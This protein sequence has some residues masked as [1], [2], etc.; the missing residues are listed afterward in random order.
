MCA[1]IHVLM[2][3]K[4]MKWL[5]NIEGLKPENDSV[6]IGQLD[7]VHAFVTAI[8]TVHLSQ[9]ISLNYNM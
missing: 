6:V 1:K 2:L 8:L 3:Y 7:I 9:P 4:A 5:K